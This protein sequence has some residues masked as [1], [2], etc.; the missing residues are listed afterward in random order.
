MAG[1]RARPDGF[2]AL[3]GEEQDSA[4]QRVEREQPGFFE[5]LVRQTY[6]GYY[7]HAAVLGLLGEDGPPQPRGH[8]VD[9]FQLGSVRAGPRERVH[10]PPALTA[11]PETIGLLNHDEVKSGERL[12]R[13]RSSMGG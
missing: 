10:L 7:S 11:R 2:A 9:P 3:T 5:V 8:R 1:E 12:R 6:S 4:L 13:G